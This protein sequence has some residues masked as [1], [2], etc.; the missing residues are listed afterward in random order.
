MLNYTSAVTALG[1][2]VSDLLVLPLFQP[3]V[4]GPM[5]PR[6]LGRSGPFVSTIAPFR[7]VTGRPPQMDPSRP[8]E[9][10]IR[11]KLSRALAPAH[12]EVRNE[13]HLHAVPPGSESHFRVLVVSERFEGL[14]LLQR[15][16]LVNEALR[17]ELAASVHALAIQAKTPA[18]WESDPRLA[19]SPPCLGG[20][21]NDSSAAHKLSGQ[22]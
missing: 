11:A 4:S 9:S 13:S 8:V 21:K 16:R 5:L 22:D 2:E 10:A 19:R 20:S 17:D 18:Q 14:P 12:L 3:P 15:H 7:L 1:V 6:I